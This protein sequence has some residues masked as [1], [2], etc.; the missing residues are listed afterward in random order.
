MVSHKPYNPDAATQ[1]MELQVGSH[2]LD[3]NRK[4]SGA[5][6]EFTIGYKIV[7]LSIRGTQVLSWRDL[8]F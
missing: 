6:D 5:M 7:W 3:V 1:E 8:T 2:P 4:P